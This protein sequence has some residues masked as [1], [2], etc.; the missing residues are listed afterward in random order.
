M[1]DTRRVQ[2][3]HLIDIKEHDGADIRVTIGE[4]HGWAELRE[5]SDLRG[6]YGLI[7]FKPNGEWWW[8]HRMARPDEDGA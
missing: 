3:G 2:Q 5:V 8:V 7:A 6:R 4:S 1:S